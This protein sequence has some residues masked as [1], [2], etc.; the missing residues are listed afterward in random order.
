MNSKKNA[1]SNTVLYLIFVRNMFVA[2]RATC[3]MLK[4]SLN[5]SHRGVFVQG[6]Y[7]I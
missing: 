1:R 7:F 5:F 4:N 3:G 6:R 2:A